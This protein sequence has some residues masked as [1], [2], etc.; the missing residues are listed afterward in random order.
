[1]SLLIFCHD[2]PFLSHNTAPS[3]SVAHFGI[4]DDCQ[5]KKEGYGILLF[6]DTLQESVKI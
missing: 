3:V 4:K 1:M 2:P 6:L 5:S